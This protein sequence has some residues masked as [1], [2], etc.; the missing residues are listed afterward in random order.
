MGTLRQQII[1]LLKQN[2]MTALDLS[3]AIG[4]SEKDIYE[5]LRH[6]EK[7][8]AGQGGTLRFAPCVCAAC[9]FTFKHRQRLTRP[10]RCPRCRQSRIS[11]PVFR[12][13]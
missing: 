12:I 1:D 3:Q 11:Y 8:I 2:P 6:I 5:H 9:G 4:A 7:S 13:E 10:G